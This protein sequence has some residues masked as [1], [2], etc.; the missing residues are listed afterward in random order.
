MTPYH[1][2]L[3]DLLNREHLPHWLKRHC[4]QGTMVEVGTYYGVFAAHVLTFWPGHLHCI[5]PWENLPDAEYR[6]GCANGGR[7]G[8]VNNMEPIYKAAQEN[9]RKFGSR[10]T[11]HQ[12]RSKEALSQFKDG[13]LNVVYL[14]GNHAYDHALTDLTEWRKKIDCGGILG[15]HDCY[16]RQDEVQNC[17]TADAVWDFS[18]RVGM[19]PFL[20]NCTSAWWRLP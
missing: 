9:L 16:I 5:D 20:T 4:P 2:S 6:D 11:I 8:G 14:D 19:R 3:L 13:S 15:I 12:M 10:V 18:T 1:S 7:S 17:G